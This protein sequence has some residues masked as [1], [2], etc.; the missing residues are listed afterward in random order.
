MRHLSKDGVACPTPVATKLN[1]K[2]ESDDDEDNNDSLLGESLSPLGEFAGVCQL[3]VRGN[4]EHDFKAPLATRLLTWVEGSTL[5]V[6]SKQFEEEVSI[7]YKEDGSAAA[8]ALME[9]AG[10]FLGRVR[11]I[12]F[13]FVLFLF[14]FSSCVTSDLYLYVYPPFPKEYI[15]SNLRESDIRRERITLIPD[16]CFS[17]P[18]HLP[19]SAS[20]SYR[21]LSAC[22]LSPTPLPNAPTNGTCEPCP[23][24][25]NFCRTSRMPT[26]DPWWKRC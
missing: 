2:D 7:N 21:C 5:G 11:Y 17:L 6:A 15:Q 4:Q 12:R 14:L 26:A 3:P 10:K 18:L 13:F 22:P 8:V 20:S 25:G 16:H 9:D 24:F 23:A 1:K 19:L